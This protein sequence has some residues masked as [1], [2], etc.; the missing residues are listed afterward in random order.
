MPE[1]EV[2]KNYNPLAIVANADEAMAYR[3]A[4]SRTNEQNQAQARRIFA[5]LT[6]ASEQAGEEGDFSRVTGFGDNPAERVMQLHSQLAG[7]ERA[8]YEEVRA[9]AERQRQ[10]SAVL[11]NVGGIVSVG[12][13]GRLIRPQSTMTPAQRFYAAVEE[14]GRP[15]ADLIRSNWEHMEEFLGQETGLA[16]EQIRQALF[17][18]IGIRAAN[19]TTTSWDPWFNR[20]PGYMPSVSRPL[21]IVDVIP[22]GSTNSDTVAWMEETTRT[23]AA[24]EMA[25]AS[26]APESAFALTQRTTPVQRIGHRIPVTEQVMNDVGQSSNYLNTI[27]PFS[28]MQRVDGQILNGDGAAPNL[29]GILNKTGIGNTTL[30]KETGGTD[31]K[32]GIQGIRKAITAYKVANESYGRGDATVMPAMPTHILMRPELWEDISLQVTASVGFF[33]GNPSGEFAPRIWGVPVLETTHLAT[34]APGSVA[35]MIV[36]F[37][38]MF[39]TLYIREGLSTQM[40]FDDQNFSSFMV[41]IRSSIR[42]ALAIRRAAAFHTLTRA[43]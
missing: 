26:R 24:A 14:S 32:D 5:D 30:E 38:G 6:R 35:G 22:M 34:Y 12:G 16:S 20:E 4:Q 40:G 1:L 41:T 21:Q 7:I 33:L 28:V 23:S 42:C 25:E 36:D 11:R 29:E 18:T 3:A 31:L 43:T 13:D 39:V 8:V 37:T 17:G 10:E 9:E 27:M 19:F 15:M 2:G